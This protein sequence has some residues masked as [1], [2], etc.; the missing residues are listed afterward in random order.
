[1]LTGWL[2]QFIP[3]HVC[4]IEAFCG[5]ASL[6]FAK[7]PSKVEVLNDIDHHLI[8]FFNV[9]KHPG[10]K[11][12][13]TKSLEYFPY[14]RRLW[15]EIR[16]QWKQGLYPTEEIDRSVWWFYLNRATFSGD[17][18]RGGFAVPSTTGRNPAKTFANA[19]DSFEH[20]A[21]RLRNTTIEC[22]PYDEVIRRYDSSETLFY[23]D[24]PYGGAEH[25]YGDSFAENDHY[26]LSGLL[27]SIKGCCMVSHYASGLY[28]SLYADFYRHEYQSFKGSHKSAGE[29]K[30]KTTECIWLNY[31]HEGFFE[32]V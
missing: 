7:E 30:P 4:Y 1:M 6:L 18:E 21:G 22:L 14:S 13:L 28:N 8:N 25:Y 20:V 23:V 2:R 10:K 27:H 12:R 24:P 17:Q 15:E 5:A 31:K 11:E 32:R 19:I 26:T 16:S 9:L 29:S 3:E